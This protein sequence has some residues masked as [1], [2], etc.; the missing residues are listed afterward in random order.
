MDRAKV[1]KV[2][3]FLETLFEKAEKKMGKEL[4]VKISV[5]N[6]SFSTDN[7]TVK[8]EVADIGE[9]GEVQSREVVDFKNYASMYGLKATDYGKTFKMR[10]TSYKIVGMKPRSKKY[11]IIVEA[12]GKQYKVSADIVKSGLGR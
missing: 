1:K 9:G 7:A 8:I 11:P 12:D 3:T 2:R 5:G 10:G 4:G 6:I